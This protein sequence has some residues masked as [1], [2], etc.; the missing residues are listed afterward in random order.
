LKK[1]LLLILLLCCLIPSLGAQ[2]KK[3]KRPRTPAPA[4]AALTVVPN[5]DYKTAPQSIMREGNSYFIEYQ[6][7]FGN[8]R[9]AWLTNTDYTTF[10][11][12]T[13]DPEWMERDPQ[14][15]ISG[16]HQWLTHRFVDGSHWK[17]R[18]HAKQFVGPPGPAA[19]RQIYF[20][21]SF[22]RTT[23]GDANENT[24]FRFIDWNNNK[25]A[26]RLPNL[27]GPYPRQPIF[28]LQRIP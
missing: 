13:K 11:P 18:I 20:D 5:A 21:M 24:N 7:A 25:W 16:P 28:W 15:H 19:G 2:S 9:R 26:G 17:M 4:V 8:R 27:Y 14:G 10:P 22:V 23:G 1:L 6:D 12:S 3:K